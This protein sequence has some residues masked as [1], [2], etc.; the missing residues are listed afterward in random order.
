M[1][2]KYQHSS[3]FQNDGYPYLIQ[4]YNVDMYTHTQH[5]PIAQ[6][7]QLDPLQS[8][9]PKR[10]SSASDLGLLFIKPVPSFP[11][12]QVKQTP[13]KAAEKVV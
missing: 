3:T 1:N 6:G 13:M 4:S 8:L 9:S 7:G 11:V 2:R 5:C 10:Q 12:S